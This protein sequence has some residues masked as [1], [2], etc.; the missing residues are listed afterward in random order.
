MS[1]MGLVRLWCLSVLGGTIRFLPWDDVETWP[2]SSGP[3]VV[4]VE[5]GLHMPL[6]ADE[7]HGSLDQGDKQQEMT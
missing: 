1:G 4:S 5:E 6:A 7:N 3:A 2:S